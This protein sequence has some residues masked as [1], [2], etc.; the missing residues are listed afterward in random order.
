MGRRE[1]P[2]KSWDE[3]STKSQAAVVAALSVA[4]LILFGLI[5]ALSSPSPTATAASGGGSLPMT[6]S[7]AYTVGEQYY[8]GK[9]A[10]PNYVGWTLQAAINDLSARGI[11]VG[12]AL[13][14]SEYATIVSQNPYPGTRISQ[15]TAN[16][17]QLM[18]PTTSTTTTTTPPPTTTSE[19]PSNTDVN[20]DVD[21]NSR[22]GALTGG[23]CRRKWWC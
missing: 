3:L 6:P 13:P 19:A 4:V 16:V 15:A 11:S 5:S 9:V 1:L 7:G 12:T 21:H 23:Y 8:A 10:M 2:Q 18:V 17:I 22:D 20:V 14:G